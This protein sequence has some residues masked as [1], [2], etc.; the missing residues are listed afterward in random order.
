MER[1]GGIPWVSAQASLANPT[2][3]GPVSGSRASGR[4]RHLWFPRCL[5]VVSPLIFMN[6]LDQFSHLYPMRG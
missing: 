3:T 1:D 5:Y 6:P 4:P 2:R